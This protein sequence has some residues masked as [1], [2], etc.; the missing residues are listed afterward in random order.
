M[1]AV[2]KKMSVTELRASL[3]RL[4]KLLKKHGEIVLVRRGVPMV[5]I[6]PPSGIPSRS[7]F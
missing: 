1:V 5:R 4:D 2:V 7:K 6:L 3:S